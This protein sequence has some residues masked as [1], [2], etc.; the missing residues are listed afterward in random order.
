MGFCNLQPQPWFILGNWGIT[1]ARQK[2]ID[3]NT[4]VYC[5]VFKPCQGVSVPLFVGSRRYCSGVRASQLHPVI[6]D[7]YHKSPHCYYNSGPIGNTKRPACWIVFITIE[8]K[9][10]YFHYQKR[11]GKST[12]KQGRQISRGLTCKLFLSYRFSVL[13]AKSLY[14][15]CKQQGNRGWLS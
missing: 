7:K 11:Y 3:V 2:N 13:S 5:W 8:N 12:L 14:Q 6:F 10:H 1:K 9:M 15:K 4:A